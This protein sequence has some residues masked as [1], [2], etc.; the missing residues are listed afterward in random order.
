MAKT[1][2]PKTNWDFIEPLYRASGLSNY[3]IARQYQITHANSDKHKQTLT[4]AAIRDYAKRHKWQRDLSDAVRR[5]TEDKLLRV[6]LRKCE[7]EG[8]AKP[9]DEEIVEAAAETRAQVVQLHRRDLHELDEIEAD[10]IRRLNDD[11]DQVLVGWYEGVA[12]EHVV[13]LGLLDRARCLRELTTARSKRILLARIAWGLDDK[14]N[15]SE[16]RAVE[17]HLNLAG[18]PEENEQ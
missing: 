11:E 16:T 18:N 7:V 10:I 1:K 17:V 14:K 5:R 13:K 2:L 6:G 15:L 8:D 3:E 4:E 12:S 9:A